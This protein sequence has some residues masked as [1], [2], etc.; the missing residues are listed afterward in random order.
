MVDH[1]SVARRPSDQDLE[2]N[3]QLSAYAYATRILH[4]LEDKQV[5][6]R[7]DCMIKNKKPVFEQRYTL[8]TAD[9]DRKFVFL[10]RDIQNAIEKEAFYP[11]SGW[12]CGGCQV[13]SWCYLN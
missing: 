3:L 9:T 13:R 6:V 8:R 11:N 1:K 10:A 5:L 7:V 12:G 4:E 2:Q